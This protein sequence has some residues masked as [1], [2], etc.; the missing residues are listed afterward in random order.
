MKAIIG[1]V[2]L[3]LLLA[4]LALC[5]TFMYS[6]APGDGDMYRMSISQLIKSPPLRL[7]RIMRFAYLLMAVGCIVT[8]Y[9]GT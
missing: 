2:V 9:R 3:T 4:A 6:W 1:A 7:R 8:M 5:A